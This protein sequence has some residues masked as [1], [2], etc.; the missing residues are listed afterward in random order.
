[1]IVRGIGRNTKRTVFSATGVALALILVL[2]SW[3]MLDT[4]DNLISVQ[5]DDVSTTNGQVLYAE[6]V[7]DA[8][9]AE[10]ASVDGVAD[11]ETVLTMPVSVEFG[12]Q[13]YSTQMTGYDPD[14]VMH[15]FIDEDGDP[16]ALP[17]DGVLIDAG[18]TAQIED[19]EPG[20]TVALTLGSGPSATTVDAQVADFTYQPLGTF[21]SAEKSWLA[22]QVPDAAETTALLTTVDGADPD[23]VRQDA[24]ELAGVLAYVDT[25][26]LADVYDEYSGLFYVFIGAMLAL[27]AAM[28]F[29]IIFTTM[30]VNIVERRRE[31]ATMRAAGVSYRAISRVVGGENLLVAAMGVIPGLILGVICCPVHAADLLQRPVHARP[32]RPPADAPAGGAGDHGRR[33]PVP[34]AGPARGPEDGRRPGGPRTRGVAG[35]GTLAGLVRLWPVAWATQQRDGRKRADLGAIPTA[36][37]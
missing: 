1:M 11:V 30:T 23:A 16:V 19:L 33:R 34:G 37:R 15:G 3:A 7:T 10:L 6:P 5:F 20:D 14:T 31:L 21:V 32:V 2:V 4:M 9:V 17:A 29:A 18:I 35:R 36:C 12:G 27:G 13:V 25:S 24:S 8:Q 28:A 22:A 26:A